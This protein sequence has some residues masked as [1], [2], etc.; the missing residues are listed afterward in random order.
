[1]EATLRDEGLEPFVADRFIS[2]V[3]GGI[4][5]FP[6]RVLIPRDQWV[7]ACRALEVAGLGAEIVRDAQ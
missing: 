6:Q 4:S 5:A 3:E 2:A 1:M 7:S